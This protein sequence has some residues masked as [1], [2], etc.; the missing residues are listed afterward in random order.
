MTRTV[1][2]LGGFLGR[3]LG[4]D[5]LSYFGGP[6]ISPHHT[7]ASIALRNGTDIAT[8]SEQLG[9]VDTG[10]TARTY[11]H[12]SKESDRAAADVLDVALRG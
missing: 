5:P 6:L 9:H 2:C 1:G 8:V 3:V 11:L 4:R 10:I 7:M 12:G